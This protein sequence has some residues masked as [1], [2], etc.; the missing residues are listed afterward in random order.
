MYQLYNTRKKIDVEPNETIL[1]EICVYAC[2]LLIVM[3]VYNVHDTY[4][5]VCSGVIH[6]LLGV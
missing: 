3:I 6:M 4:M 5:Y 2:F 1:K